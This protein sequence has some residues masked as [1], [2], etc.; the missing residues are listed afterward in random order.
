[1]KKIIP[2]FSLWL[3]S[4]LIPTQVLLAQSSSEEAALDMVPLAWEI[5]REPYHQQWSHHVYQEIEKHLNAFNQAQDVELF[6]PQYSQLTLNQRLNFWGQLISAISFY[7]SG[8]NPTVRF[9]ESTMGTDPVTKQPVH[10]EGLLQLSYQDTQWAKFCQ[11]NWNLDKHLPPRDPRKTILNPYLNLSCGIGILAR[12]IE[13]RQ[14]IVLAKGAY[15]SVI[16]QGSRYNRISRIQ[17]M[18]HSHSYCFANT[19]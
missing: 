12:Q 6:C 17:K 18:I 10:S 19:P 9:H 13:R 14:K 2:L 3:V 16:K 4:H 5:S 1:M 7:E 11:F 15:W 8:W